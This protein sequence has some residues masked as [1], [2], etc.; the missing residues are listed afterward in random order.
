LGVLL[1][2]LDQPPVLLLDE[3]TSGLDPIVQRTVWEMVR[4]EAAR[5]TTVFFSSHVISEVEHICQRVAVLRA[6]R[7]V[8]VEPVADLVGRATHRLEVRFAEPPP[9]GAFAI[10]D[11]RETG[12]EGVTVWLEVRGHLDQVIQALARYRVIDLRTEQP[13]LED[14]LLTYYREEAA[15]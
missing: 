14:I 9:S 7:L 10:P 2:L 8:A 6:G 5:G 4:E 12:R 3:P 11:V 13:S 15:V 1:A